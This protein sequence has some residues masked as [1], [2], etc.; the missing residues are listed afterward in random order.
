MTGAVPPG[1]NTCLTPSGAR[2]TIPESAQAHDDGT[3]TIVMPDVVL[4]ADIQVN[5]TKDNTSKYGVVMYYVASIPTAT[6]A[7][8]VGLY[9]GV[10]FSTWWGTM[11]NRFFGFIGTGAGGQVEY[12]GQLHFRRFPGLHVWHHLA[13]RQDRHHQ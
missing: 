1:N 6:T 3:G 12:R 2:F 4:S 7:L 9:G 8:P 5:V 10:G 11:K 13:H